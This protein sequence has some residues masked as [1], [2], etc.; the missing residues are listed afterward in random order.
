MDKMSYPHIDILSYLDYIGEPLKIDTFEDRLR[1][2]RLIFFYDLAINTCH[3]RTACQ[4]YMSDFEY[5][6][7]TYGYYLYGKGVY[8]NSV[9]RY[10]IG[11]EKDL[12]KGLKDHKKYKV[13]KGYSEYIDFNKQYM[14]PPREDID[15]N[16]WLDL[17]TTFIY[18]FDRKELEYAVEKT[19][20]LKKDIV[21]KYNIDLSTII[22]M[23]ET[24]KWIRRLIKFFKKTLLKREFEKCHT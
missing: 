21:D 13:C 10:L 12:K 23:K 5:R 8:S 18:I 3:N 24:H 16:E 9:A 6:M 2:Q 15:E 20:E 14:K 11:A 17:I 1:M 22:K 4:I 7:K 19:Y